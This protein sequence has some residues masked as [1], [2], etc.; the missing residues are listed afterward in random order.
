MKSPPDSDRG[1]ATSNPSSAIPFLDCGGTGDPAVFLHANGFPPACYQR[2]LGLLAQHYRT[3]AMF[4]RPLWKG[5]QPGSMRDWHVLSSD[6]LHFLDGQG[7]RQALVVG[8]SMGAIAALR[9]ALDSP[10]R[11][12]ALVLLEPVL[13]PRRVMLEW[14]VVRSVGLGRR[15]HP[16]IPGALR[17]QREFWS[18][19]SAFERY[20]PRP[21]FRY[22]SDEA[23]RAYIGGMTSRAADGRY[24]LVYSPE[25]EAQIYDTGVWNDGDLWDRM[26]GLK[27]PTLIVRGAESDTLSESS[28]RAAAR[29]SG[30]VRIGVVDRSTH[31]L[32]LER[33]RA[34]LELAE[35]FLSHLRGI[36]PSVA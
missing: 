9:A 24:Q 21:I 6:L 5:E 29:K 11:F 33:P 34:A 32:P 26:P 31:L 7:L 1:T 10:E 18:L 2:L 36:P 15:L 28:I 3:L 19:E 23:L 20:R 8:H 12:T 13:L 14:R 27:V 25:W 17:R 35:A 22:F 30:Q 4:Q 16:L